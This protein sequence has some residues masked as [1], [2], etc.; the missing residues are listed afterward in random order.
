MQRTILEQWLRLQAAPLGQK[1]WRRS[2]RDLCLCVGAYGII[3]S[4]T[5]AHAQPLLSAL[6][7]EIS[8]VVKFAQPAV[9][10]VINITKAAAGKPGGGLFE[11]FRERQADESKVKVGTGLIISSDGFILT[12]ES[13]IRDA[14]RI[15]LSLDDGSMYPV[16]WVARDSVR[17][18][19]VLKIFG[20]NLAH[21]RIGMQSDIRAGS[22]ITVIGNSLGVPHAVSVGV[23]SAVQPD[24]MMQISANVDPGSN[25][26]PVF[27]V[28]AE[29]I[30]IVAG[31][32]SVA[33]NV[34]DHEHYFGSTALVYS[35]LDLMPFLQ[36][37][38]EK[39]YASHGWIGV[40][41]VTDSLSGEHPRVLKLHE[42]GPGDKAGLQL[43]DVITNFNDEP[44]TSSNRLREL[45]MELQPG[46]EVAV[47][48][49]REH[50]DLVL[51][52]LVGQKAPVALQELAVH[53]EKK[54]APLEPVPTS[55]PA[56]ESGANSLWLQRRLDALERE[57]RTL[58]NYYQQSVYPKKN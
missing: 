54:S 11:F 25:G 56:S 32:I 58:Q 10:T 21:A 45:V 2:L 57:V 35:L 31:R 34:N 39:Y 52:V 33:E 22:W 17:G 12:K 4:T 42:Q 49:R 6:E 51:R 16:E 26:S 50:Q 28:K 13:V 27:N 1:A 14:E 36:A 55:S 24:G 3:F 15:E 20:Q 43:G 19:A 23:I 41:V 30:G 8:S 5:P 38:I 7:L 48:V 46:Q 47:R 53:R 29:A 9:V 40:T 18:I 44:V 37:S